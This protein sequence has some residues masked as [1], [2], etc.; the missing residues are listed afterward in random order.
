MAKKEKLYV[1]TKK[2]MEEDIEC[3]VQ[4]VIKASSFKEAM[5]RILEREKIDVSAIE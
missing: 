4:Y 2:S 5:R 3:T 1:V